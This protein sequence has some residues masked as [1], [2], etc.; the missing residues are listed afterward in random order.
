MKKLTL[1]KVGC[2]IISGGHLI[3]PYVPKIHY[4]NLLSFMGLHFDINE[5]MKDKQTRTFTF[6]LVGT[7]VGAM[8]LLLLVWG[9][10]GKHNKLPGGIETAIPP[11]TVVVHDTVPPMR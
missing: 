5:G 1:Y 7:P 2:R 6:I 8:V 9:L 4:K 11:D 3:Q 10:N